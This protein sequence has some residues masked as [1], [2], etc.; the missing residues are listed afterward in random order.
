MTNLLFQHGKQLD[1]DGLHT[2]LVET[3]AIINSRPLSVEDLSAEYPEPL[4]ANHLLTSKSSVVLPPPGC[5]ARADVYSQKRW[6]RVQYLLNEFWSR[7]RTSYLQSLQTR[8]K[9]FRPQRNL[10][11]S[12]I[13]VVQEDDKPRGQW[14]LARVVEVVPSKDG[15]VRKVHVAMADARLDGRG[16]RKH[17]ITY[18]ERPVNKLI[19]LITDNGDSPSEEP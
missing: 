7:W 16:R 15:L 3:E 18:L 6:R 11:M 9:W 10:R 17:P 1:E 12:D 14:R 4:T 13:V 8:S 19:L 2:F 5:F